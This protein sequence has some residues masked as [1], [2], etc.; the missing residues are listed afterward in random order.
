MLSTLEEIKT[1]SVKFRMNILECMYNFKKPA[2][3][4]SIADKMNETPAKIHYHIKK[5]EEVGIV[6]L[7]YTETINGIVAKF[8]EPT[9]EKFEISSSSQQLEDAEKFKVLSEAQKM[10][11]TIYD[12][13]K[14]LFLEQVGKIDKKH[15]GYLMGDNIYLTEEEFKVLQEEM[16]AL[17]DKYSKETNSENKKC[18]NF[19]FSIIDND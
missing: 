8:Y 9:A 14:E 6:Q 13:S 16:E 7:I 19:F 3:V 17:K 10:L 18:Y 5:L 2:T 12:S 15:N 4:K 1:F 11:A